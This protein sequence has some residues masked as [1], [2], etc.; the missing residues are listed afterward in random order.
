MS[1]LTFRCAICLIFFSFLSVQSANANVALSKFRI[2]FDNKTRSNSL[3]IRNTGAEDVKYTAELSLNK[4][5]E[6]GSIYAVSEDQYDA[7][8]FLRFSPKRGTIAPGERQA[9]RFALRKPQG[10]EDGEYRAVMRVISELAPTEGGNVNLASKL[11][12]NIP[13]IVR[14]GEVFVESTLEEPSVVMHN[15][16][17]HVEVWQTRTGN[18]SL[19]GN[20]IVEAEDGTEIG[21]LNNVATYRPLQRRKVLIPLQN[22]VK[23][24]VIIKYVENSKFGGSLEDSVKLTIN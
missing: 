10:L 5:T 16:L 17:P 15:G 8:K 9:I 7:T 2:Y 12:Y 1:K 14:H 11:A 20:F 13:I 4:M 3:Q 24:P 21:V 19:Y 22:P 6:D 23:G 18:R